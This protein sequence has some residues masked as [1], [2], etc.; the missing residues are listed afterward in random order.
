[1]KTAAIICEFDP[2][3]T[4][5]EH[6]I[7][8]VRARGA[9]RIVCIMSG[10]ACQRGEISVFS[11]HTRAKAALAIGA[12]LVLELPF[13]YSSASAE[14]FAFGAMS[15]IEA[16]GCIDTLCF[17]CETGDVS[18]LARSA[19][20][21]CSKEFEHAY[22][23][24]LES[25]R[26]I[27]AAA[28]IARAFE[29]V[30]GDGSVLS[31]ANNTLAVEYIKAA[32]KLGMNIGFSAVKR[33]GAGHGEG[34]NGSFASASYIR[35][36]LRR[37][38]LAREFLPSECADIFSSDIDCGKIS[39]GIAGIGDSVLSHFRLMDNDA[40]ITAQGAGG[41]RRRMIST[42]HS[43]RGY[44]EFM[45]K[46]KT[47]KYTDARL[48]RAVIFSMCGVTEQ[49]LRQKPAYTTLLGATECG[50]S[51]LS[52]VKRSLG[53]PILSNPSMHKAL[54]N[55]A[56]RQQLLSYKIAAIRSLTCRIPG[57]TEDELRLPPVI[58]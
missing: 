38:E 50:I 51:L 19:D 33:E 32:K 15:V 12:D 55:D 14:F 57:A 9:E 34:A 36:K 29:A 28:A 30:G 45:S 17:G 26:D 37:G 42:A 16:L 40:P 43:C 2:L 5:H 31:G 22:K 3:H 13:P 27:G 52:E 44:D 11:K 25:E 35:E 6:L 8:T 20:I 4:G 58:K 47:K 24:I 46:L 10:D 54:K 53:M 48:R 23:D 56:D 7:K 39:D 21:L 41:V 1:M 18:V 49:D